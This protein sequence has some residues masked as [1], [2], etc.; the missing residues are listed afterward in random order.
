MKKF[1][2]FALMATVASQAMAWGEREQGVL[3]GA[4][5]LW[6]FQQLNKAGQPQGNPVV[7]Q[8]PPQQVIIQPS[9]PVQRPQ[10][11]CES[12]QVIDQ[13][14]QPRLITFCYYR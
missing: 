11:Y 13:F 9:V 14:G 10:Q 8:Q 4:A 2:A 7:V 12:Q 1:I 6:I 3:A 5:G